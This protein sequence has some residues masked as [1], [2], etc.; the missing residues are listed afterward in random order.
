LTFRS[1]VEKKGGNL[2]EVNLALLLP[3]LKNVTDKI[4]KNY[5]ENHDHMAKGEKAAFSA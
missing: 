5:S 1:K 4:L 2:E 3:L